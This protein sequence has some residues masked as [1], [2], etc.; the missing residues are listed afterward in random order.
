MAKPPNTAH[1]DNLNLHNFP[2]SLI[3]SLKIP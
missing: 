2:S 1:P 3:L